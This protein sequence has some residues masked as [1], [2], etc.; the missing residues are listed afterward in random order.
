MTKEEKRVY[1]R[2]RY[3]L[4]LKPERFGDRRC[5]CCEIFLRGKYGADNSRLYCGGCVRNGAAKRDQSRRSYKRNREKILERVRNYH[6]EYRDYRLA[7][8]KRWKAKLSPKKGE[9]VVDV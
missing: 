2:E 4:K 8:Y 6:Q 1:D 7:Y 5:R 9:G 3:L